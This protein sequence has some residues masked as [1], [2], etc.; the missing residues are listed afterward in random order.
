MEARLEDPGG[1]NACIGS[2]TVSYITL[3][4]LPNLQ[5]PSCA[6]GH[7]HFSYLLD[8]TLALCYISLDKLTP[9]TTCTA[10]SKTLD[11]LLPKHAQALCLHVGLTAL[12]GV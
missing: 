1:F 4:I 2:Y 6:S 11:C 5:L 8:P 7:G 9:D 12:A 10:T 3:S